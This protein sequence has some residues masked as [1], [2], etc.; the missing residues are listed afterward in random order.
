L[1]GIL[2]FELGILDLFVVRCS[3]FFVWDLGFGI[4]FGFILDFEFWILD[5]RFVVC[6]LLFG[7][8]D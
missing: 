2:D 5:L 4:Y 7:I 1:F 8:L 6:C 3:A